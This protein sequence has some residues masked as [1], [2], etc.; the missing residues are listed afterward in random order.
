[1]NIPIKLGSNWPQ[2]F[3][4]RFKTDNTPVVVHM[5]I[6]NILSSSAKPLGQLKPNT[7]TEVMFV[8]WFYKMLMLSLFIGSTLKK[9][10]DPNMSK[11]VL[12]VL[13]LLT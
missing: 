2:W 1:M 6:F 3:Q 11:R 10:R 4:R 9:T 13:N 12:S 8:G 7:G 5:V